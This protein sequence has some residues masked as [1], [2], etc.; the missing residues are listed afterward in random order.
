MNDLFFFNSGLY[1]Y[2]SNNNVANPHKRKREP[3][4]H[5][6]EENQKKRFKAADENQNPKEGKKFYSYKDL[7]DEYDQWILNPSPFVQALNSEEIERDL[8][9]IQNGEKQTI[10]HIDILAKKIVQQCYAEIPLEF[11]LCKF[12]YP[13]SQLKEKIR[14]II[15]KKNDLHETYEPIAAIDLVNSESDIYIRFN[16]ETKRITLW[17]LKTFAETQNSVIR[18]F[19]SCNVCEQ[20]FGTVFKQARENSNAIEDLKREYQALCYIHQNGQAW[21]IQSKP[22][23]LLHIQAREEPEESF[24]RRIGYLG[25][26][27][28]KDYDSFMN[29]QCRFLPFTELLIDFHQL[30]AALAK[31]EQVGVLHGDI[32]LQN[33]FIRIDANGFRLVHLADFGTSVIPH[34]LQEEQL[35]EV[36]SNRG[37]TEDNCCMEDL[38]KSEEA[39]GK[40]DFQN[41]I[42]IEKKGDVFALGST[43]HTMLTRSSPYPITQDYKNDLTK[44]YKQISRADVPNEIK[45]LIE[46]MV[47]PNYIRRPSAI[48][49]FQR[50]ELFLQQH[51]PAIY[52]NILMKIQAE[53]PGSA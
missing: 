3:N 39:L 53:Y 47:H 31:L 20:P 18:I 17:E 16:K 37:L 9:K 51:H 13:H 41:V 27:Y 43:L 12:L 19:Y 42:A 38:T 44:P 10:F 35:I 4:E 46:E 34:I 45:I 29:Y 33:I 40:R 48:E 21:G 7:K 24:S 26:K 25:P 15:T 28:D 6:V 11:P 52:E 14:S 1:A 23:E 5:S 22:F 30:F 36:M 32:K 49:A 50:Y 2:D 8:I